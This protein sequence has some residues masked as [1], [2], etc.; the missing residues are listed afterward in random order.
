[1]EN[2]SEDKLT[3]K[4]KPE[5]EALDKEA[6][7]DRVIRLEKHLQQ[8]KNLNKKLQEG[9]VA[10]KEKS[11]RPFDFSKTTKRHILLRFYYLGWDY[12]GY[13]SQE[14]SMETI[15]QYLLSAMTR[16]CL[17]KDR[18]TANY[19]RCGRTDKGVSAFSQVVSIDLRSKLSSEEIEKGNFQDEINYCA[20]LNRVLPKEIRCVSWMPVRNPLYSSRFD[21]KQRTYR[22]FFPR[23]DLDIK[24]MQEASQLLV[25][26]HDFRNFCKMDVANGVTMFIRNILSVNIVPMNEEESSYQMFFIEIVGQAFLYHQI[27]NIM[28]ILFLIGQ[29]LEEPEIIPELLDITKNPCKPNYHLAHYVPL[30][31]YDVEYKDFSGEGKN[32]EKIDETPDL[33]EWIYDESNLQEV[34]ETLQGQWTIENVKASMM[35]SMLNDLTRLY[36]TKFPEAKEIKDQIFVLRDE[37]RAKTYKPLMERQKGASLEQR[38][39][40]VNKKPDRKRK[41]CDVE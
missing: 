39:E 30:N 22:Y 4:L 5:L 28:T 3:S 19:Q 23:G 17:I 35:K 32:D 37:K 25:G 29:H 18:E 27:R 15:E 8:V 6:L 16:V 36:H 7:I 2:S 9:E 1:M 33:T 13:A 34:I 12:Q 11:G 38:L 21:C 41:I 14:D 24:R 10:K 20:L 26:C 40:T 31:L